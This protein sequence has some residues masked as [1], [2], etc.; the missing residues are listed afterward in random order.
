MLVVVPLHEGVLDVG[1]EAV[2]VSIAD[3]KRLMTA[4]DCNKYRVR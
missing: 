4:I 3:T 1:D 2:E